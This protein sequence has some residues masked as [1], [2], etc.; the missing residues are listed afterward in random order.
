MLGSVEVL[1]DLLGSK[2]YWAAEQGFKSRYV[3]RPRLAINGIVPPPPSFA[4]SL[5]GFEPRLRSRTVKLG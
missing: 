5:S 4:F 2:A 1:S 3:L